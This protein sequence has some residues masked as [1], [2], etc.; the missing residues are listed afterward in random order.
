[1]EKGPITDLSSRDIFFIYDFARLR[2]WRLVRMGDSEG[3]VREG[4]FVP[5]FGNG[6]MLSEKRDQIVQAMYLSQETVKKLG[7]KNYA[8]MITREAHAQMVEQGLIEPDVKPWARP[9]LGVKMNSWRR[10]KK[11]G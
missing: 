10:G 8:P 2:N 1:M 11:K 3:V 6:I 7:F 5:F 4:I 9:C